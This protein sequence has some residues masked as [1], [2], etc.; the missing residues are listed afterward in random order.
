MSIEIFVE[1]NFSE[2]FFLHTF[3]FLTTQFSL[4][5]KR[6][7][8]IKYVIYVYFCYTNEYIHKQLLL[9]LLTKFVFSTYSMKFTV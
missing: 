2:F 1:I 3:R 7:V 8:I 4:I 5:H 6:E 9:N